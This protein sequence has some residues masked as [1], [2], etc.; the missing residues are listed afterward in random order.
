MNTPSST[1]S[2]ITITAVLPV[3][4]NMP[5]SNPTRKRRLCF[6][7][8]PAPANNNRTRTD[9][10][11]VAVALDSE[12]RKI[13]ERESISRV[14]EFDGPLPSFAF[15]PELGEN[16]QEEVNS[17]SS[18]SG[19]FCSSPLRVPFLYGEDSDDGEAQC[20]TFLFRSTSKMLKPRKQAR[21]GSTTSSTSSFLFDG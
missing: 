9:A 12:S 2:S 8:I 14:Q 19:S 11:H 13:R 7:S 6:S 10:D 21:R 15:V 3:L 17:S 20:R 1:M 4:P 18:S 5:S 16:D